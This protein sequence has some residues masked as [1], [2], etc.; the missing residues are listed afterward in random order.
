ML[1]T[2]VSKKITIIII[3]IF[4]AYF[5]FRDQLWSLETPVF[6]QEPLT[7]FTIS[8][9][10]ITHTTPDDSTHLNDASSSTK[11]E[12]EIS[13]L[14][15]KLHQIAP[16]QLTEPA[17]CPGKTVAIEAATNETERR[18]V[19]PVSEEQIQAARIAHE[20]VVDMIRNSSHLVPYTPG[21]KGIV[22]VAGG[23]FTG[24][25][26]VSIRMLRRT[27]STLPVEVFMPNPEDYNKHTCEV[28]LP[29]L[30]A[31]CVMIP[32]YE[33]LT[34]ARY[35]YKIFAVML[36]SFEDVL[37]LD[38]D[39]FPIVDPIEWMEAKVY[40]DTGYVL[41]PDFWLATTSP[42]YFQVI[43][44]PAPSLLSIGTT[45][46]GQV[47]IS[48]RTHS[49]VL[50]LALYY[51]IFG[52]S[53]YY[54]LLTQC[55]PGEGD[56]ETWLYAAIALEKSYF[57]V[58]QRTGVVGHNSP[59][60]YQT[61]SMV[62]HNP[63]NDYSTYLQEEKTGKEHPLFR[64]DDPEHRPEVVFMHHNIIK[65]SPVEMM[66]WIGKAENKK[67]RMWGDRQ[68]TIDR[69]KVDLEKNVWENVLWVA[70]QWGDSLVNWNE[71][72]CEGLMEHWAGIVAREAEEDVR[73]LFGVNKNSVVIEN[74][75]E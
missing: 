44:I 34:I 61:A 9:T 60:G 14:V 35:Q 62:Q 48:K 28:V 58:R 42:Y 56:K 5:V 57:Q 51:N 30:N 66:I 64:I 69:F 11:G 4:V 68:S 8:T 54:P 29:S 73:K 16:P 38:A 33:N 6:L 40:K 24:A 65:L 52:P 47:I 43:D 67:S 74:K 45:E 2:S 18:D 15:R 23:K 13:K 71:G 20:N 50:L 22:T 49:D 31:R 12:I 7:S 1:A 59:D 75:E 46:S 36:S 17:A 10:H 25:L 39:N 70:C 41:W 19:T 63:S 37:F 53:F 27:N 3:A 55:D 32:Q 26:L 21:S 72:V